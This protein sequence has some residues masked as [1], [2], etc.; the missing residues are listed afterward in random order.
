MTWK[1]TKQAPGD[2]AQPRARTRTRNGA[3]SSTK[4]LKAT[5][6]TWNQRGCACSH[7]LSGLGIGC[8][9]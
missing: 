8:V 7:Q 3:T 2:Q 9:S 1:A 6:A 4:W 5:P